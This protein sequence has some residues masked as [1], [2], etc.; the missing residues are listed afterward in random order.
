M[1]ETKKDLIQNDEYNMKIDS[2]KNEANNSK[3]KNKV[4]CIYLRN[5][6]S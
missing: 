2:W 4:Q 3:K 6:Q 5:W 1:K